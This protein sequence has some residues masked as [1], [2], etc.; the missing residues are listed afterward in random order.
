M[1]R[2]FDVYVAIVVLLLIS[3]SLVGQE[4]SVVKIDAKK[5]QTVLLSDITTDVIPVAIENPEEP[6]DVISDVVY[7]KSYL[8]IIVYSIK[9][10]QKTPLRILQYDNKGH[11]IKET[12]REDNE[13]IEYVTCDTVKN[14][15]YVSYMFR[16]KLSVYSFQ[17][18]KKRF[19][20]LK[21]HPLWYHDNCF[22]LRND[23]VEQDGFRSIFYKYNMSTSEY[24]TVF[25][26]V[27]LKADMRE[28]YVPFPVVFSSHNNHVLFAKGNTIYRIQENILTPLAGF[29]IKPKPRM[30]SSYGLKCCIG[31]YLCLYYHLNIE[32]MPHL[33]LKNMKTGKAYNLKDGIIEDVYKTGICNIKQTNRNGY[34][35]F[36]KKEHEVINTN[37]INKNVDFI[38]FFAK[39][40]QS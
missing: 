37:I 8:F 34:F 31:D 21:G 35:Y 6:F 33:Y 9:S 13:K 40:Q 39:M 23:F 11:F 5:Y 32:T 12:V 25:D 4:Y 18:V 38:I 36:I 1:R 20:T 30:Y 24:N 16:K 19:I 27:D 3:I 28:A 17:G 22:F 10:G 29:S 26:T 14:E 15:L 7:A 2:I